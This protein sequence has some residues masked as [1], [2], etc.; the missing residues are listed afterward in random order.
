MAYWQV[1]N[2]RPLVT[3]RANLFAY[4][5]AYDPSQTD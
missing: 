2:P 4:A 5:D 3:L 1:Q